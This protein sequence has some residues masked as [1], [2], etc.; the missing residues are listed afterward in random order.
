MIYLVILV[1][2]IVMLT[3]VKFRKIPNDILLV[4]F[5]SGWLVSVIIGGWPE[6]IRYVVHGFIGILVM[7]LPY[8]FRQIGGGDVKL[9]GLLF[10]MLGVVPMIH[11]SIYFSVIGAL[12]V[13]SVCMLK[14][15]L[16]MLMTWYS[17][18]AI[19]YA[20]PIH[21]GV[22]FYFINGGLF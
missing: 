10:A 22:C 3:D 6:A 4:F 15:R 17:E 5:I 2:F 16:P 7:V 18:K 21:L 12:L 13:L 19:P 14:Y 8:L 20:L 9:I 11:I 1:T